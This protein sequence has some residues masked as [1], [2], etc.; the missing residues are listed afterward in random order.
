LLR[1]FA[2]RNDD[3]ILVGSRYEMKQP[4]VYIVTN[5]RNGTLYAGVTSRLGGR[6]WEHKA[7]F[8]GG[9]SAKYECKI[10]VWYELHGTMESAILREKQIKGGSRKDKLRLIEMMNPEWRDLFA[11]VVG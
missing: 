8:R 11:D 6:S 2:P 5:K 9:F 1:R 10:L 3:F 4:A 7:G